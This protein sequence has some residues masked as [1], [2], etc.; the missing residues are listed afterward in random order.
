MLANISLTFF[1]SCLNM[2][3]LTLAFADGS[4]D[5]IA[6]LSSKQR[7]SIKEFRNPQ[8][9]NALKKC[10]D[11]LQAMVNN[12]GNGNGGRSGQD[13]YR[14]SLV[15]QVVQQRSDPALY[16]TYHLVNEWDEILRVI[17]KKI[18]IR[19]P[20]T[21][22][23]KVCDLAD[24]ECEAVACELRVPDSY[25]V[26]KSSG[27]YYGI[28][29]YVDLL[30][31]ARDYGEYEGKQ[32]CGS[33]YISRY[34]ED[35]Y[36]GWG[37]GYGWFGNYNGCAGAGYGCDFGCYGYRSGSSC[38]YLRTGGSF[39]RRAEARDRIDYDDNNLGGEGTH[40]SRML[41]NNRRD[42]SFRVGSSGP[43]SS[44]SSS[45]ATNSNGGIGTIVEV[46]P[47]TH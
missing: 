14:C 33:R 43:S 27:R 35:C 29:E 36:Y 41:E 16:C 15:T 47:F 39:A 26:K 2:F 19:N 30:Q 11:Q 46:T 24:R 18:I 1:L 44:P 22:N 42:F 5:C 25:C 38:G 20:G 4:N 9:A 21:A 31:E 37:N 12:L 13:E 10:K 34:V 23:R 32:N 28:V 45:H 6:L 17:T 40:Y 8:C 3:I 7:E